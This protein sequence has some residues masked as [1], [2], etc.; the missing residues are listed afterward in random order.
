[1][2]GFKRFGLLMVAAVAIASLTACGFVGARKN[3]HIKPTGFLLYGHAAVRL[4]TDDRRANGT[5]CTAPASASDVARNTRVTVLDPAGKTMAI[6]A[7]DSGVLAHD[8]NV[9]TCDFS[10]SIPAVP[11]GVDTYSIQ[12]GTRAAQQ[13]AAKTLRQNTPAVILITS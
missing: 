7:L 2:S 10:F 8:N 5:A 1:V 11:G 13:F 12:I 3:S 6:G 4:P 9:P